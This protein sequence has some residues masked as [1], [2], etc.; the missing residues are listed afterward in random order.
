MKHIICILALFLA[1]CSG[2]SETT[3]IQ[4]EPLESIYVHGDSLCYYSA[5]GGGATWPELLSD[6]YNV[7]IDCIPGRASDESEL[8][9]N[10]L[11]YGGIFIEAH[12]V[13]DAKEYVH[14]QKK[15]YARNLE[16]AANRNMT[17]ICLIPPDT[18]DEKILKRID[19][20]QK[21]YKEICQN[22]SAIIV[23]GVPSDALDGVHYTKLAQ[24]E[25]Y[26]N[27]RQVISH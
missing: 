4:T 12:G 16:I 25:T 18:Q 11:E 27:L 3:V 24:R 7:V 17:I 14:Y 1:S 20:L 21:Q 19:T 22:Y 8:D 10:N 6:D 9:P 2:G 13:N 26:D 15:F 23:E 5:D